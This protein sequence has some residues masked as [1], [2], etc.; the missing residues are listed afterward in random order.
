M[1]KLS[2]EQTEEK[3]AHVS[4]NLRDQVDAIFRRINENGIKTRYRYRAAEYR[5]CDFL[6]ENYKLKNLKNVSARHIYAYAARLEE[7]EHKPSYIRTELSGIRWFHIRSGSK[8]KLPSN[9][10]LHLEKVDRYKYNRAMLPNEFD[11]LVEVADVKKRI[12]ATMLAPIIRYFGLR[13]EEAVTLRVY[14]IED[15]WKYKQLHIPNGKGGQKRDV[16]V[17]IKIQETLLLHLL[18][19]AR[20]NNKQPSDYLIFDSRKTS[21]Q[22]VMASLQNWRTNNNSK[23]VNPERTKLVEPGKKPRIQNPSWHSIRHLYFQENKRRMLAEGKMTKREVEN[24]LSRR[25]GHD[26]NEVKK[27]YSDDIEDS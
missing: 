20:K 23:F 15:A 19:Y 13:F 7:F 14:Q 22:R 10:E 25:M 12:D 18:N 3:N 6:A 16:P 4:E 26:R 2:P 24:E 21:V 17:D 11:S 1:S 9:Q 8:N 27:Y 5:F